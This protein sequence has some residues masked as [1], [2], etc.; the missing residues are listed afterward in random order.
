MKNLKLLSMKLQMF[1]EEQPT[2]PEPQDPKPPVGPKPGDP[3]FDAAVSKAV[4]TAL[5]NNNRKWQSKLDEQITA[6]AEQAKSEAERMAQMNAEQ[7]AEY[8]RDKRLKELEERERAITA[9]ELRTQSITQ[10]DEAK[11]PHSLVELFDLS[12]S[13]K[14]QTS[15]VSVK[16][17]WEKAMGSWEEALNKK[18]KEELKNSVDNPLGNSSNPTDVNPWAKETFNLTDQGRIILEDPERAAVLKAQAKR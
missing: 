5:E 14:A 6:A 15:F 10:L 4:E 18:V 12:D 2:P 13:E 17:A 3:E 11:L 16:E 8:E 9:R 7:K 1:G